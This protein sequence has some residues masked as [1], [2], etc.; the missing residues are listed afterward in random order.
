MQKI[1]AETQNAER[2]NTEKKYAEKQ[3]AENFSFFVMNSKSN[4]NYSY[5]ICITIFTLYSL[6]IAH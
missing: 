4:Y 5:L 2:Q 3:N 6:T 1:K